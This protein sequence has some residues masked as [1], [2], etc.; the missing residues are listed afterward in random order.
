MIPLPLPIDPPDRRRERDAILM[1]VAGW[2][3][4]NG[5]TLI[6]LNDIHK[7]TMLALSR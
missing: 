2:G 1:L 3:Q 6:W 4:V 7:S 5:R